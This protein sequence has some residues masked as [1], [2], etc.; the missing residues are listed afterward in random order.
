MDRKIN[1]AICFNKDD[2]GSGEDDDDHQY[3][4]FRP[5]A[6]AA[7]DRIRAADEYDNN[8]DGTDPDNEDI[9]TDE[10][11][12]SVTDDVTDDTKEDGRVVQLH[13]PVKGDILFAPLAS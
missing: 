12:L 10:Y 11:A 13:L 1:R 2:S 9:F 5:S 6:G 4:I 8:S 7:N 3:G